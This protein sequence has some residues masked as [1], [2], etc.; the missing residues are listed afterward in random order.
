[1]SDLPDNFIEQVKAALEKLYDFKAL[2]EN[3]LIKTFSAQLY[4]AHVAS[5]HK[6][7]SLMIEA[8]ETLNHDDNV[9]SQSGTARIYHLIYMHY[10]SKLHGKWGYPCGKRIGTC[11]GDKNWSVRCC[12]KNSI[13]CQ[14]TNKPKIPFRK[15]WCAWAIQHLSQ[16]YRR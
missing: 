3:D 4:D 2:Q 13:F 6:L 8:I 9:T 14:L 1:M 7:R 16:T 10:V 15:N 5:V 11:A 12:G